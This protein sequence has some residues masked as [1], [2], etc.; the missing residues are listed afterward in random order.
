MNLLDYYVLQSNESYPTESFSQAEILEKQWRFE[1]SKISQKVHGCHG[2]IHEVIGGTE[3]FWM[4]YTYKEKSQSSN[5]KLQTV[6]KMCCDLGEGAQSA[7]P[8]PWPG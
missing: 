2:N 6:L 1:F 4:E 7:P 3:L 5:S 8:A